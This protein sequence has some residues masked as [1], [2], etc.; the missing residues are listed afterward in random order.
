MVFLPT[1]PLLIPEI[2]AGAAHDLD[3]VRAAT[4][5]A[6]DWACAGSKVA[7]GLPEQPVGDQTWALA[8]FGVTIGHG[9]PVGL[10]EGV[11]RWLLAGRSADMV[12]PG[13]SLSAYDAVL[14]VGDGSSSRTDKAPGH[15]NPAAVPFDDALLAALRQGDARALAAT[16][17]ELADQVGAAGAPAWVSLAEQ[18]GQVHSASVDLATDPFGVLYVVARWTVRWADPA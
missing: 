5:A 9:T 4:R 11:A 18:V 13:G 10:A 6:V 17:L 15:T 12:G 3:A 8:G 14:V 1:P 2:A 7:A 16:D